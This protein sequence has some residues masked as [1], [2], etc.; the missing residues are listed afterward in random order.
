M[1]LN[2]GVA[3]LLSVC[4][5]CELAALVDDLVAFGSREPEVVGKMNASMLKPNILNYLMSPGTRCSYE[6]HGSS[7][8]GLV[9]SQH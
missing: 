8:S 6:A 1:M 3:V 2:A 4:E 7:K 9:R 5:A